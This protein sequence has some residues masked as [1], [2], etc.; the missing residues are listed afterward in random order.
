MQ[1]KKSF[2]AFLSFFLS[3]HLAEAQTSELLIDVNGGWNQ[4]TYTTPAPEGITHDE[5]E[6]EDY[7]EEYFELYNGGFL[8]R[9]VGQ[10]IY[11]LPGGG[12]LGYALAS[13][14]TVASIEPE[15]SKYYRA[16]FTYTT[17][18]AT[19]KIDVGFDLLGKLEGG[20]WEGSNNT[21][22]GPIGEA[23]FFAAGGTRYT[24]T[25][26]QNPVALIG[27][28]GART[29]TSISIPSTFRFEDDGISGNDNYVDTISIPVSSLNSSTDLKSPAEK[30]EAVAETPGGFAKDSEW[31]FQVTCSFASQAYVDADFW[32]GD[33]QADWARAQV[34]LKIR[35]KGTITLEDE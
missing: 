12:R 25:T 10:D 9:V 11:S 6:E 13:W 19:G 15:S 3:S 1:M 5:P 21:N 24:S 4:D 22:G 2:L 23:G 18:E 30:D 16:K 7:W 20:C 27:A 31:K 28:V 14:G 35:S 17:Y 29:G 26:I 33:S 34:H 32:L 8:A